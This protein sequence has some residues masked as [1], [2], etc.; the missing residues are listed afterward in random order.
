MLLE[1]STQIEELRRVVVEL[2]AKVRSIDDLQLRIKQ[3]TEDN[4]RLHEALLA[5]QRDNDILAEELRKL[6]AHVSGHSQAKEK[7]SNHLDGI[8]NLAGQL[9]NKAHDLRTD[10]KQHPDYPGTSLR[11]SGIGTNKYSM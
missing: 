10:I 11:T 2:D 9:T 4:Q 1:R 3:L 5:K 7:W 6:K 8:L